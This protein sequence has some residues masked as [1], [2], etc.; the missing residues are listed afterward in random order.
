MN[1]KF[2]HMTDSEPARKTKKIAWLL[3]RIPGTLAPYHHMYIWIHTRTW[4]QSEKFRISYH[5][6][7][8]NWENYLIII[9][10]FFMVRNWISCLHGTGQIRPEKLRIEQVRNGIFMAKFGLFQMMCNTR[11]SVHFDGNRGWTCLV[12]F[13]LKD[14]NTLAVWEYETYKLDSET[15]VVQARKERRVPFKLQLFNRRSTRPYISHCFCHACHASGSDPP[16][17]P[18]V[19]MATHVLLH[20]VSQ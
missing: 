4:R 18:Q 15:H 7:S 16:L 19:C 20:T 11:W 9:R 5:C 6:Q 12:F 17:S 3:P 10:P 13:S 1:G 2:S 14:G 8:A